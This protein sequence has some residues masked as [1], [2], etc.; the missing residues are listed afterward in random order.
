MTEKSNIRNFS[1]IAH[2][3]HGKSTLADRFLQICHAVSDRDMREQMLDD[4]ELER[5]RGITI[6]ARAV[7]LLYQNGSQS[8]LLNLIDTPGHVDFSYEVN[9]SLAACEGALL[10]VDATQ[11]IQAQTLAHLWVAKE[12]NLKI[13]GVINKIDMPNANVEA[14][15]EQLQEIADLADED[16]YLAS[17]K[18]GEGV[19]EILEAVCS[20][21][22]PPSLDQGE[23]GK[24]KALVFDSYYD[25]FRG[26][27]SILRLISGSI[28]PGDQV[29]F[30]QNATN[31]EVLEIGQLVPNLR[32]VSQLQEGMVGYMIAN[33]RNAHDVKVGD[34]VTHYR[35]SAL[36]PLKGFRESKP[37]VFSGVYPVDPAD[38]D[39]LKYAIEK[40][41]LN[42]SSL[43]IE[44]ETSVALGFGFRVGFL[45]LL[46]MEI[47]QER[48]DR[49]Y[50]IG[51]IMTSPSVVYRIMN[52]SG[53]IIEVEN[54]ANFPPPGEIEA[55][56]EPFV[57]AKIVVPTQYIGGVMRLATEKR[58]DLTSTESLPMDRVLLKFKIPLP[59]IL[60]D[61]YDK[62]K[63][64]TQGYG[65]FD[66]EVEGYQDSDV[67]KMDILLNGD[68]V[69]AF[70]TIVH[71]SKAAAVGRNLISKLKDLIPMHMFTIPIQ[72]AVGQKI[73]ARE[74]IKALRKN[75][76]AKCYGGDITR[77]KKLLEKQKEG[78]KRMKQ[79]GKVNVP[80]N[81]FVE[82]L[83]NG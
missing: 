4:M 52:K 48:I 32:P 33:I 1:I 25:N 26:V 36:I 41:K 31:F 64:C 73:I 60:I 55:V 29:L 8:V 42:D 79:I 68:I 28:K 24:L 22:P 7:S 74:T 6:K 67:V 47:M 23:P 14:A 49:E 9:R 19:L 81:A 11:G 53:D 45:G 5:E 18:T 13:L 15:R 58:G 80:K 70:S 82:V 43:W 78:K 12:N 37:M 27:V 17:G 63:S 51:I 40:L 30:M 66:Y 57:S 54:P 59:E 71:R 20:K 69:D 50:D 65:S 34:T 83:K 16:I 56:D 61:F 2:I 39:A 21:I 3:D 35:N 38:Y 44:P 46:H 62:L 72:A 75:V 77:K 10:L 76:T